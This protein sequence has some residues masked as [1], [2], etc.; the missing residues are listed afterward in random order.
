MIAHFSSLAARECSAVMRSA[1][2]SRVSF[3]TSAPGPPGSLDFSPLKTLFKPVSHSGSPAS[4]LPVRIRSSTAGQGSGWP[5]SSADTIMGEIF[6]GISSSYR[7]MIFCSADLSEVSMRRSMSLCIFSRCA[8]SRKELP[9]LH[10]P[11]DP[12]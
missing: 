4:V 3:A 10:F 2:A 11:G 9:W 6:L 12:R 5:L 8:S 1:S 7:A